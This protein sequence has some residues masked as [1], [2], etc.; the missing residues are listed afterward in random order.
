MKDAVRG[1]T[2]MGH[3][4][5]ARFMVFRYLFA[6]IC[7]LATDMA[8]F[9]ALSHAGVPP[10]MAAFGG[11]VAGMV[12]HWSVSIRFVFLP[13]AGHPTPGHATHAQRAGFVA[14][15]LF[16]MGITMAIVGSLSRIGIIPAF[17]KMASIPVSFF[18]VYAIRKYGVFAA[19]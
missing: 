7:A 8:L 13:G 3:T 5:V 1:L 17:A 16:G 9:L 15:A 2:A 6:S 14:S 18:T 11:Y 19:R 10:V 4:L 12:V